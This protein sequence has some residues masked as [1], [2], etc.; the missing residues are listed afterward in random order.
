MGY[1]IVLFALNMCQK[2]LLFFLLFVLLIE[3]FVV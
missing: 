1:A 2:T 3:C